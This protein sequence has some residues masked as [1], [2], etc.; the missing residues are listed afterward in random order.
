[1]ACGGLQHPPKSYRPRITNFETTDIQTTEAAQQGEIHLW[2]PETPS[3]P[4]RNQTTPGMEQLGSQTG[5]VGG[6]RKLVDVKLAENRYQIC[7]TWQKTY[8]MC[9]MICWEGFS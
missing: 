6:S 2:K 9:Y 7:D 3:I 8:D 4:N 1:M 5:G